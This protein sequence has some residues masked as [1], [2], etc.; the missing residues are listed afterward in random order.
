MK[1]QF[2]SSDVT[3]TIEYGNTILGFV[4]CA[5]LIV[6]L[7][8]Y[9]IVISV[10]LFPLCRSA[11]HRCP[12]CYNLVISNMFLGLP[13]MQDQVI[14]INIGT[15]AIILTRKVLLVLAATCIAMV[16]LV[17]VIKHKTELPPTVHE[18]ALSGI[19]WEDYR[20]ECGIQAFLNNPQ[21]AIDK[22]MRKYKDRVVGWSGF[23]IKMM[24]NTN[25]H[26]H[27]EEHSCI[28]F[29]K[30]VPDDYD[31]TIS[32]MVAL[33]RQLYERNKLLLSGAKNGDKIAF[34]ATLIGP[35]TDRQLF[36]LHAL[37]VG[38]LPGHM[39]FPKNMVCYGRYE[40]GDE[41]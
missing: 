20:K 38:L 8:I 28:V 34:N 10:F 23:I 4:L 6:L 25:N 9:G 26:D 41:P 17:V 29:I 37:G 30:M 39:E 7:G 1:C 16:V 19:G 31:H 13:T 18:L 12:K 5:L 32:L 35:G 14:S 33:N 36:H 11:N 15:C 40:H 2:C 24:V 21:V 3:T 27:D 22:F